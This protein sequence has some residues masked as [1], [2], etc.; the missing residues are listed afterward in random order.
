MTHRRPRVGLT[1]YYKEAAWGAWRRPAALTP[2]GY[3]EAVVRCGG[4][5]LLLPP[6]GTDVSVLEVL[7]ALVVIGGS[8]VEPERYGQQRHPASAPEPYRDDHEFALTLAALDLSLPLLAICRGAQVLNVAL[9]GDL[10]QHLPEVVPGLAREITDPPHQGVDTLTPTAY[11]PSPG[12]FGEVSVRTEPGSRLAAAVGEHLDIPCYHHQGVDQVA[13]GLVVTG[14]SPDGIVQA[15]EPLTPGWAL[16]VQFHPEESR[17]G[18]AL[19][20]AL[21]DAGRRAG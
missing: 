20:S 19:F 8:D 14:R 1:T 2:A 13:P 3:V 18:D 16:G 17:A 6:V 9:G 21:L 4:T 11:Q 7:D 10:H 12:V 5:P 15:L